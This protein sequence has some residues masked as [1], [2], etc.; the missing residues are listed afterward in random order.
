[1]NDFHGVGI[2]YRPEFNPFLDDLKNFV[3]L[4]EIVAEDSPDKARLLEQHY[5][6]VSRDHP[7]LAHS[8]SLSPGSS[9]LNESD[10]KTIAAFVR[11][12]EA[13]VL[14]DHLCFL[15]ADNFESPNFIPI[16]YVEESISVILENIRHIKQY[17][18]EKVPFALENICHYF[19]WNKG[20]CDETA[21]ISKI[22]KTS[23][24]GFLLDVNNLYVNAVNFGYDPYEF[25]RKIPG[26]NVIYLHVAGHSHSGHVLMDSHDTATSGAVWELANFALER[27]DARAII[28]ERDN[29]SAS[30]EDIFNEL[31]IARK[32][33]QRHR[34]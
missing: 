33:W 8:I 21:F 12:H 16:P 5:I 17:L 34:R 4:F 18:P 10:L 28:L 20:F 23:S 2:S 26:E 1:M 32:I 13:L 25:I 7:I 11:H 3:D 14:S 31:K 30:R 9:S 29:G 24:C 19:R 22:L 6:E 27:T 15:K